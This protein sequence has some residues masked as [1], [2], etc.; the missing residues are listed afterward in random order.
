MAANRRKPMRLAHR[1]HGRSYVEQELQPPDK[2]PHCGD[3]R[4][5]IAP[6]NL[7]PWL[8]GKEN[9]MGDRARWP[10]VPA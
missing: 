3:K 7:C 1:G 9:D 4:L 8:T 10:G 6:R 5:S 2:P